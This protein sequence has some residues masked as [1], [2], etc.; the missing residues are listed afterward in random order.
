MKI[1]TRLTKEQL[2]PEQEARFWRL[3]AS[4]SKKR[5]YEYIK[6]C[7]ANKALVI[8]YTWRAWARDNQLAPEGDWSTWVVKAGRGWG[9][10]RTGAEWVIE[11]AQQYPGCHIALVG[12]TVA[13]VRKV[14]V[15]GIS[16][17]LAVSPPWF[18]PKYNPSFRSE[19]AA[20]SRVSYCPGWQ[21][22][23]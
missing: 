10:T 16:G 21:N 9:K 1:K 6:K 2:T 5:K 13:D 17:I 4:W 12:R 7:S 8:K 22:G 15:N 11:K 18:Q 23:R 3:F 19:S 14:M 20:I